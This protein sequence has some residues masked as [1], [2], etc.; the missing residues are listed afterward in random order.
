MDRMSLPIAFWPLLVNTSEAVGLF[1]LPIGDLA[2]PGLTLGLARQL[3]PLPNMPTSGVELAVSNYPGSTQSLR[4]HL[5]DRMH[6]L[7]IEGPTGTGKSWLLARMIVQ[8]IAAGTGVIVF[9]PKADLVPDVLD[10]IPTH[11][12]ND[13]IVL[14]PSAADRPVGFNIMQSAHDEQSRELVVD[15]SVHIWRELYKDS[16]GPRSEDVLRA[17]ELT[18][19]NARSAD[20]SA[21]TLLEVPELLTNAAFRRFVLAQPTVPPA[22]RPFWAWY[23]G[24][25][26]LG[27][28]QVIGPILNKLRT[29]TLRSPI[30]L[31]LGQS[32]GLDIARLM[33]EGKALLARLPKGTLGIETVALLGTLLLSSV[34][35]SVLG[36]VRLPASARR[37]VM[38]Y[39]DEAQDFLRLPLDVA[40]MVAQARGLG[41]G[42]T[43][44]HQHLGQITDKQVKAALLGTMRTTIAFQCGWEDAAVLARSYAPYLTAAD[45]HG[46]AAHEIAMRPCINGQTARPVSGTTL[47]LGPVMRDGEGVAA[48]SRERFGVPRSTV[49]AALVAR[50][51]GTTTE[52][53]IMSQLRGSRPAIGR[54]HKTSDP[55][56]TA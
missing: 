10:R 40:D 32:Q 29:V 24:L 42:F 45:L 33:N 55:R 56:G 43:L 14:D 7:H 12:L 1:P 53:Q 37:P 3:P 44:A 19:V 46:L 16:W 21:F 39:I 50:L 22:V 28:Q 31:T 54:R 35:L 9:D 11:R 38:V 2:L 4:L 13:V 20:G 26:E 5:K 25:E 17:S 48:A 47:P 15:H 41:V 30:R 23:Q 51:G 8:D 36:R 52:R 34:W 6:G 49:E 18:L 27:R